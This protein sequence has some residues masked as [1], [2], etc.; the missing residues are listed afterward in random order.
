MIDEASVTDAG[1][2]KLVREALRELVLRFPLAGLSYFGESVIVRE[3]TSIE[4]MDTDGRQVRY[5]PAWVHSITPR[6]R[7]FDLLHEWLHIF[8]N[9]PQR[10]GSREPFLW[11]IAVDVVVVRQACEILS[12]AN[13]KWDPPDDGIIPPDWAKD[14]NAEQI[15]DAL[16]SKNPP[17]LPRKKAV[18]GIRGSNDIVPPNQTREQSEAF[19][20]GFASE[21]A[22]ITLVQQQATKK[23]ASE[24]YPSE[25]HSR[26]EAILRGNV[27]WARLLRGTIATEL[28]EQESGYDP[29]NRRHYPTIILPQTY[30]NVQNRLLLAVDVSASVGK[31]LFDEFVANVVPAASRASETWIVSF[32]DRIR[33]TI[34]T[35]RPGQILKTMKFLSGAHS[36]TSA[37]EV[38]ELADRIKPTSIVVLTD[39]YI[40]LPSNPYPKTLWVIPINGGKQP[41]G[42]TY[43]M[44]VSW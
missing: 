39:G 28:G 20:D 26:L 10:L 11:N 21:L 16:T 40:E 27:P 38:F 44:E 36:R 41:W 19:R 33:E 6:G 30:D 4:T 2:L 35:R 5:S 32:D 34:R 22:Q 23:S 37:V 12:T 43:T 18:A 3:N 7:V 8:G 42:R 9:H 29:P 24:L 14:M 31:D 1:A 13:D 25:L 15:Y 17:P